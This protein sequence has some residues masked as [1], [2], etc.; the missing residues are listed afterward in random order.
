MIFRVPT[1]TQ[2]MRAQDVTDTLNL[3]LAASGCDNARVMQRPR[4]LSD[5][6]PCYVAGGLAD[7][8]ADRK[9]EHTRGSPCHPQTR[10]RSSAGTRRRRTAFCWRT[11]SCWATSKPGS[12]ASSKTTIIG[13]TTRASTTSPRPTS[14]SGAATPSCCNEKGSSERLSTN[15]ACSTA[16]PPPKMTTEMGQ[17]L[18]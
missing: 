8:L 12:P 3:A 5:N 1:N 16:T 7:W 15:G 13:D 10:A 6:G 9:M 14:T 11:T 2:T 18:H 4:L 17:S